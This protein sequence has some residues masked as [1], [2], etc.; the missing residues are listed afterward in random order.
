MLL[1]R[2]ACI[3]HGGAPHG[4]ARVCEW[5]RA[6]ERAEYVFFHTYVYVCVCWVRGGRGGRGGDGVCVFIGIKIKPPRHFRACVC[7]AAR[8]CVSGSGSGSKKRTESETAPPLRL[9]WY[10]LQQQHS[11]E[12]RMHAH[13]K[14]R[15]G[16]AAANTRARKEGAIYL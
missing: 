3:S 13:E 15:V 11:L 8:V 16:D 9:T 1:S 4:T 2:S 5:V 6:C 7:C 14:R 12:M 10:M